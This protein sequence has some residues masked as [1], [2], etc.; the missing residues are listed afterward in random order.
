MKRAIYLFAVVVMATGLV[1]CNNDDDHDFSSNAEQNL[2][3]RAKTLGFSDAE[4]YKTSVTEQCAAGNHANCDI[5]SNGTHQACAYNDHSGTNHD[6]TYHN[7]SDHGTH[8]ANG[9][10]HNSQGNGNHH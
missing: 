1:A 6:G 7:G 8:D 9:H 3:L 10:S 5:L 2:E 4:A